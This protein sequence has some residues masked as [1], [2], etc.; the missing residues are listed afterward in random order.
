ML[1][2]T[3][4]IFHPLGWLSC[5][6]VRGKIGKILFQQLWRQCIQWEDPLPSAIADA[7]DV[8]IQELRHLLKSR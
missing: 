7:W 3:T 4:Q 5:F 1:Q 8:W 2:S 6:I